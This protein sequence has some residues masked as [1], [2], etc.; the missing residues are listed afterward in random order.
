M[1]LIEG[2]ITHKV[3][4]EHIMVGAGDAAGILNGIVKSN[5]TAAFIIEQLKKETTEAAI[6]DA[7][8]EE[9]EAEREDVEQGVASIVAKLREIG[10]IEE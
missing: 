8:L 4:D 10:A 5:E 2:L 9:Y 3:G 6:V 1:K 7:M